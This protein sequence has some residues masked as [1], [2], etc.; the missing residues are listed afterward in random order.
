[1]PATRAA[2]CPRPTTSGLWSRSDDLR[3]SRPQARPHQPH[4]ALRRQCRGRVQPCRADAGHDRHR[5]P[6]LWCRLC[7][8]PAPE[9]CGPRGRGQALY[10]AAGW[11][12]TDDFERTAL[13][14][15]AGHSL[16]DDQIAAL[17]VSAVAEAFCGCDDGSTLDCSVSCPTG[18]TQNRLVRVTLSRDVQLML[19]YPW[20]SS[21]SLV[22]AGNAV[23]RVR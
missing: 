10:D 4:E 18:S 15:Y 23:V 6:G 5:R 19:P 17:P 22:V 21:G 13:E 20:A 9:R 11:E 2:C 12:N 8:R 16:S 1:M 14:E 7:R 3:A